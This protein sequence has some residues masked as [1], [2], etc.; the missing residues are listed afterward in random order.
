[1]SLVIDEHTH[2]LANQWLSLLKEH[3]ARSS[4]APA[5]KYSEVIISAGAPFMIPQPEMFDYPLR[6]RNMN[7]AH[8]DMAIVSLTCPNV[9]W[10]APEISL[11]AARGGNPS[12]RGSH[13]RW[14][15]GIK[16]IPVSLDVP[17]FHSGGRANPSRF[18]ILTFGRLWA[19]I[20]SPSLM[21]L[22]LYSRKAVRA[23][24]SLGVSVPSFPR[25]MPRLM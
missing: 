16:G 7:L 5:G 19:S 3:G 13:N 25:G 6:I 23:Y 2:M 15:P 17:C 4:V 10:G 9:Y 12:S 8:V 20:T 1:M 24:T 18:G 14:R 11:R 22:F 21:T